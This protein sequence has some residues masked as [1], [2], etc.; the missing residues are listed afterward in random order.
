LTYVDGRGKAETIRLFLDVVGISYREVELAS[1]EEL[2]AL[3]ASGKLLFNQLPLLEIN[4]MNLVQSGAIVRYLAHLGGLEPSTPEETVRA[5]MLAGGA[6]DLRD[7][8]VDYAFMPSEEEAI[9][10]IKQK[11]CP[12]YFPAFEKTLKENK[13][14]PLY[15][16]G[17]HLTWVDYLLFEVVYWIV[18]ILPECL[19]SYPLLKGHMQHI[20][21]QPRVEAFLHSNRRKPLPDSSYVALVRK[22]FNF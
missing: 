19:A 15:L 8:V 22:V 17:D 10:D 7:K 3:R 6:I 4:G 13:H 14:G 9:A 16:V 1:F 2:Q 11:W 20:S 21:R 5:E 12:K 18:E